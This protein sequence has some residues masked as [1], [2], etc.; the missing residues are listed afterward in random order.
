[1]G[2]QARQEKSLKRLVTEMQIFGFHY[3]Y[4]DK[5]YFSVVTEIATDS[6]VFNYHQIT[7][8]TYVFIS[9]LGGFPGRYFRK[10][11]HHYSI[12]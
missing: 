5:H 4:S 6:A 9:L 10:I 2:P 3:L 7:T 8:N 12:S 1:V 11:A